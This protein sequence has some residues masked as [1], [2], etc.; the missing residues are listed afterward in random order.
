MN[1][2][3]YVQI[4]INNELYDFFALEAMKEGIDDVNK[5]VN[6]KSQLYLDDKYIDRKLYLRLQELHEIILAHHAAREKQLV[7]INLELYEKLRLMSMEH[8]YDDTT[9]FI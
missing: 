9:E 3:D 5:Y 1:N 6:R 4:E 8:G 2:N 7:P